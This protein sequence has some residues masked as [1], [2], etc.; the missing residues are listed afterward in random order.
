MIKKL[1]LKDKDLNMQKE[2]FG[3]GDIFLSFIFFFFFERLQSLTSHQ[4]KEIF[5]LSITVKNPQVSKLYI[6]FLFA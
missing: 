5:S 4:T 6:N 1:K 2:N 3:I